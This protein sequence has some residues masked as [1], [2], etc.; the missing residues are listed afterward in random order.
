[1]LRYCINVSN[2][3]N[4]DAIPPEDLTEFTRSRRNRVAISLTFTDTRF[5]QDQVMGISSKLGVRHVR[6]SLAQP[7]LENPMTGWDGTG[8]DLFER[9]SGLLLAGFVLEQDCQL[10]T[11]LLSDEEV[12]GL[13]KLSRGHQVL[14]LGH[15][16]PSLDVWPDGYVSYCAPLQPLTRKP[17]TDFTSAYDAVRHFRQEAS[18]LVSRR[19][20]A[21]RECIYG[22]IGACQGGCLI[23]SV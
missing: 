19:K 12:G 20:G 5:S 18:A 10:P 15:C 23:T 22:T 13:V 11:C 14:N 9:L 16:E 7:I 17:L 2:Y 8:H 21:C 4:Q 3:L 1:M 6:W